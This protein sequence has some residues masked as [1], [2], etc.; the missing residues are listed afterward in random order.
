MRHN[1]TNASSAP[2]PALSTTLQ[3]VVS[4][5]AAPAGVDEPGDKSMLWAHCIQSAK[6]L[7]SLCIVKTVLYR[8]FL[9]A[10]IA[11]TALAQNLPIWWSPEPPPQPAPTNNSVHAS[12]A[13]QILELGE[14][15]A[16]NAT[17][18]IEPGVYKLDRP[19]VLR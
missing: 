3:C 2:W 1:F 6:N 19:L 16:P 18:L 5:R 13:Q 12:T 14:K 15:L 10:N 4:N 17:L 11:A 7:Q 9:T 8:A